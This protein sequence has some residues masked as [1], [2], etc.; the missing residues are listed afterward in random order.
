MFLGLIKKSL[1]A[2]DIYGQSLT[3]TVENEVKVRTLLGGVLSFLTIGMIIGAAWAT[4]SDLIYKN[5]PTI[6]LEDQLYKERPVMNL[7]K[8]TFP[9]SFCIQ[10]YSQ[11]TF[12]IPEYFKFEFINYK[13]W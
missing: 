9:I 13:T 12:N 4:G 11:N 6:D 2:I 1:I 10:D 5:E 3:L 8:Y 7:D